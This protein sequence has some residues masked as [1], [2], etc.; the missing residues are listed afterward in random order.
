MNNALDSLFRQGE[1]SLRA[2]DAQAALQSWL[3]VLAQDA[4]HAGALMAIA[5]LALGAGERARATALLEQTIQANPTL[6]EPW[7]RLGV[8]QW[9]DGAG[10]GR[11]AR[12][13]R[14]QCRSTRIWPKPG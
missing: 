2:G 9:A 5:Q 14:G 6:A 10:A 12:H 13:F 3:A 8:L 7:Y 4:G 1:Q 11:P